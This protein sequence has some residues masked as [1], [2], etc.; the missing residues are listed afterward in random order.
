MHNINYIR[1]NPTEFDNF[2]KTRGENPIANK[3]IEIDKVKRETQTILQNLLA[4]RNLI[5]KNIENFRFDE[6]AKVIYQFVWH[7]YCD[8]YIEFLKP[9]FDSKVAKKVVEA[10]NM[11]AFIQAN[12][13]IILHPFIPFFTEKPFPLLISFIKSLV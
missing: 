13:L 12:I 11:S 9:I 7:S 5:S 2:M 8:W 6:A 3:I 4:E 10:R 1:E